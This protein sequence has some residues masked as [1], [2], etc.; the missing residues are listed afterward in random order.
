MVFPKCGLEVVYMLENV[1][2]NKVYIE[3]EKV[4]GIGLADDAPK[5]NSSKIRA[6]FIQ[7]QLLGGYTG[8]FQTFLNPLL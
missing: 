3:Y 1:R 5:I 6:N 4:E 2:I 7:S 8:T